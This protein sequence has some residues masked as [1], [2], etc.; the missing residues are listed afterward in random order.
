M[1]EQQ[2]ATAIYDSL[3]AFQMTAQLSSLQHAQMR[4][5]LAEHLAAALHAAPA[6]RAQI[7]DEVVEWSGQQI[8]VHV[9]TVDAIA[10]LLRGAETHVVADDSDDPEHVDDCPGCAAPQPAV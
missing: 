5:Y 6:I 8:G 3:A 4:Q 2:L 9:P 7:A 1:T 10:D